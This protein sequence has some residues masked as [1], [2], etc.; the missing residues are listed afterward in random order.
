MQQLHNINYLKAICA[1][2]VCFIHF[3]IFIINLNNIDLDY[4]FYF[5]HFFFVISGFVIFIKYYNNIITF[6]SVI[7]FLKKRFL[8]LYPLHIFILVL[9]LL[10]EIIKMIAQNHFNIKPNYDP[11]I[12]NNFESFIYNIFLVHNIFGNP[13]SFNGPS[14][15][16]GS[17]FFTYL[18]FSLTFFTLRKKIIIPIILFILFYSKYYSSSV[19]Y[20][21]HGF[22]T[23][24]NCLFAFMI[25][26]LFGLIFI[27]QKLY[28]TIL[29]IFF[30]LIFII[31]NKYYLA[32]LPFLFGW[33]LYQSS[34]N[35]KISLKKDF[36]INR[37]FQLIG[38]ISYSI[39]L[40]H[41]LVLWIAIQIFNIFLKVNVYE[42]SLLN[43]ILFL[44]LLYFLTIIIA[45]LSYK[46]V[47]NFFY[48]K[49]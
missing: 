36:F 10:L 17:E 3:K 12:K 15:A 23:N 33:I 13:L 31:Y 28:S 22:S 34:L 7:H 46:Y 21:V 42:F 18:V 47:E 4:L 6:S 2:V 16:V 40:T 5:V 11:F 14:W 45:F 30:L 49:L 26:G 27:K 9:F 29:I 19:F 32:L 37:L 24:L 25:G 44:I 38:K 43:T 20:S 35:K 41:S 48:Q 1:L 8:R 39:Y